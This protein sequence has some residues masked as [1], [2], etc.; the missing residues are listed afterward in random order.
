ML[1]RATYRARQFFQG[2]RA[3]LSPGEVATARTLLTPAEFSLFLQEEPRDRRH[4]VNLLRLLRTEAGAMD[5]ELPREV[6][7]AALL[8][9][10]GK[11]RLHVW[12]RIL[13]VLLDAAPS[14]LARRVE[15]HSGA[16][17]RRALWRIRHHAALGAGLLAEAGSEMRVVELVRR[18]T[19]PPPADDPELALLIAADGQV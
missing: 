6:E 17:W 8:H 2:L 1:E 14:A 12:H 7:A 9:D 3:D 4:S 5:M 13:F 16:P 15:S 10:V 19:E 11:G 18:H